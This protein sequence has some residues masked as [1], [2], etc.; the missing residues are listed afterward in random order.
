MK[1]QFLKVGLVAALSCAT[2]AFA[3]NPFA[4]TWK[5]DY[6]KSHVTGDTITFTPEA[7]GRVRVTADARSYSF[8]PDG[9]D[10]TNTMGETEQWT[11]SD[12]NN[13][14]TVTEV[15]PETVTDIWE[16]SD[17]G[18]TLT[19]SSSGTMPNGQ[20]FNETEAFARIA[21]GKGLYGEWRSTKM[22]HNSP[23]TIQI[24]AKGDNGIIWNIPAIKASVELNFD[25]KETAH[26]G[27]TVPQ[28]LMLAA[29]KTGSHSFKLVEKMKGKLL[30]TGHFTVS[31][32]GKTLTESGRA[33]GASTSEKVVYQ[34]V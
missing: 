3:Q 2:V 28:G 21:P 20:P 29:T 6:A 10:T 4:G 14:K 33:V 13:W 34:K 1:T 15:G 32:D 24:E 23:N 12:N 19:D 16:V 11:K 27:P 22:S 17:N 30:W 9:S 7:S 25:G 31:P 18:K 26:T 5:A 8:K